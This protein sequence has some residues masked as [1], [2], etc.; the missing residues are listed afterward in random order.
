MF[1]IVTN[2]PIALPAEYAEAVHFLVAIVIGSKYYLIGYVGDLGIADVAYNVM[3]LANGHM[4]AQPG[5]SDKCF[6][7]STTVAWIY[8]GLLKL[9]PK[10]HSCVF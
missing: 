9:R 2:M 7:I 3:N 1:L 5:A 8:Y 4:V 10:T 6:F